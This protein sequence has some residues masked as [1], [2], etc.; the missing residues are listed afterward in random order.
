MC[1]GNNANGQLGDGSS[2]DRLTRSRYEEWPV[3]WY[4]P[5]AITPVTSLAAGGVKCWGQNF[6]GQIGEGW[7]NSERT[8]AVDVIGLGATTDLDLGERHTC[9]VLDDGWSVLGLQW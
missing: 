9:V 3:R 5:A 7:P 8:T 4:T 6:F 1:W 2:F